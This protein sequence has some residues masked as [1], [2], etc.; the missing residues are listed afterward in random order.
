MN[1]FSAQSHIKLTPKQ[2]TFVAEYVICR[3]GAEAARRAN[4][5]ERSARQIAAENMTKPVILEAIAAKE[6][7]L[8]ANLTLDR[9][10]VIGGLFSGIAQ[11]RQLGD[12]SGIIKG[13]LAISKLMGFDK[14]SEAEIITP[15]ASSDELKA[16]L[17][18]LTDE[19][20]IAI[21]EGLSNP[22]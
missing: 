11:A 1:T 3:N 9:D 4:Y 22:L 8:A 5:K 16:K 17:A 21:S 7:E 14:P 12:P 15:S 13:W 20:L 6:A 2:Q 10:T 19:E 18:T